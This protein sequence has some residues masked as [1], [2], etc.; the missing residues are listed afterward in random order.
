MATVKK[1]G[2]KVGVTIGGRKGGGGVEASPGVPVP[3]RSAAVGADVATDNWGGLFDGGDDSDEQHCEER[4]IVADNWGG[5][6]EQLTHIL[7]EPAATD[8]A[9]GADISLEFGPADHGLLS[10]A[11]SLADIQVHQFTSTDPDTPLDASQKL[12][13]CGPV[14]I[15]DIPASA[16]FSIF[17]FITA[18]ASN[19]TGK[20]FVCGKGGEATAY[21]A[22]NAV[23]FAEQI[24][25]DADVYGHGL[26]ST[27]PDALFH[28]V[29]GRATGSTN[30]LT[31]AKLEREQHSASAGARPG[32]QYWRRRMGL[33]ELCHPVIMKFGGSLLTSAER[34]REVA[35]LV[36]F[37][38]ETPIVVLDCASS[39]MPTTVRPAPVIM[40]PPT[41]C[42]MQVRNSNSS[43][44]L[45]LTSPIAPAS[46]LPTPTAALMTVAPFPASTIPSTAGVKFSSIIIDNQGMAAPRP[47]T[48]A[49]VDVTGP[50]KPLPVDVLVVV[51]NKPASASLDT[52]WVLNEVPHKQPW[53]P[54]AV[55][56]LR[57]LPWPSFS[58]YAAS[59]Q[60]EIQS[61]GVQHRPIP[62]PSFYLLCSFVAVD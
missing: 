15:D 12:V 48:V 41:K 54:P 46:A 33:A 49:L 28:A 61:D 30:G 8:A 1:D 14:D 9:D 17:S 13:Q 3:T 32:P 53:P 43:S 42:S 60:F 37:S 58:N 7:E 34:M 2:M 27:I 44:S 29:Q 51:A 6:F 16:A 39:T 18:R 35:D 11:D 5:L 47:L 62:W 55:L 50:V 52:E 31:S 36:T 24:R 59:V 19:L 40:P 21:P 22:P 45:L 4:S 56:P 10:D 26:T 20:E 25:N 38:N 57:P 23:V